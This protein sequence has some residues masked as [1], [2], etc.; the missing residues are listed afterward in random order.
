MSDTR[1]D[2]I[3]LGNAIVDVLSESDDAFLKA[4]GLPKG[5]MQLIDE[6]Q[7][8]SLYADMGP[9]VESSGGSAANT[10]VGVA[11]MGGRSA[12]IGRVQNDQLGEV[13]THDIRASGVSFDPPQALPGAATARCLVLVTPD[14]QRTMNTFLGCSGELGPDDV[15]PD[16]ILGASI[17]YLE[18]YLWDPEPAKAAFRKAMEVAKAG[19]RDVALSLSDSFCVDR[20]RDEFRQLVAGPVDI[21]FANE[22]EIMSLYQ[23]DDFEEAMDA[24][25]GDAPLS[26]LTRSEKGCVIVTP[27]E[28]IMVGARVPEKLVDTTGAGDLFAAGFLHGLTTGRDLATCG[29]MGAIAAAEIISHYG[30]RPESDLRAL[31]AGV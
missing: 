14:A 4:H 29:R 6:A 21:L 12:F 19:G 31:I 17:T 8:T 7:A 28:T 15:D 2:V 11:A 9:G 20:H 27:E 22:D 18:G 30:A 3:A 5:S 24:V 25:R 10:V 16:L 1:H 13:F 26:I 23:T